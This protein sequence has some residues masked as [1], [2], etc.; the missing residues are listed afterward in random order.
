MSL[1]GTFES[2]AKPKLSLSDRNI[3]PGA[4]DGVSESGQLSA[5]L[6]RGSSVLTAVLSHT[7]LY[8]TAQ[9]ARA[10]KG[11]WLPSKGSTGPWGMRRARIRGGWRWKF[12]VSEVDVGIGVEIEHLTAMVKGSKIVQKH[13]YLIITIARL[14]V[15]TLMTIGM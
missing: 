12:G 8:T 10:A 14:F 5:G 13:I 2:H 7:K 9:D 4:I 6:A 1:G 11:S 3:S 15:S